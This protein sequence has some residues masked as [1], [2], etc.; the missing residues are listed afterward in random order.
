MVEVTGLPAL[1]NPSALEVIKAHAFLEEDHSPHELCVHSPEVRVVAIGDQSPARLLG[2][3]SE[4]VA[5]P[6]SEVAAAGRDRSP[7]VDRDET[8]V[9]SVA[10][11]AV[12]R[13]LL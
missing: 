11:E 6:D 8:R 2:L 7:A 9:I 12:D 1:E 13:V 3:L 4:H 10:K 5:V